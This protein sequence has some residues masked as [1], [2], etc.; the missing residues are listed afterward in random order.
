MSGHKDLASR[1]RNYKCPKCGHEVCS[2]KTPGPIRWKDGHV[3]LFV[4][5]AKPTAGL[6]ATDPKKEVSR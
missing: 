3:C 1:C 2:T 4:E 6:S 5:I